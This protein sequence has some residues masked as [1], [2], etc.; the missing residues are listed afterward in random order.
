MSLYFLGILLVPNC[1]DGLICDETFKAI[2]T[3]STT[4]GLFETEVWNVL[5][6]Y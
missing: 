6:N 5:N 3:Y 4:I 2:Q 1:N